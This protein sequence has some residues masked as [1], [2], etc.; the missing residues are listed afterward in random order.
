MLFLAAFLNND[1]KILQTLRWL[2]IALGV[3][4]IGLLLAFAL[5]SVQ[6]RAQLPQNIKGNFLR[7]A[8]RAAMVATMLSTLFLWLGLTLGKVLKSQGTVRTAGGAAPA[9]QQ[10]GMLMVGTREPTRPALRAVDTKE[11]KKD[12]TSG[13]PIDA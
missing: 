10:E 8:L 9:S 3:L 7:V 1:R 5:D 6:I 12:G 4:M 2:M 13:Q 11:S